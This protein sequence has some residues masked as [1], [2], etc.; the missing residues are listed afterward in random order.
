MDGLTNRKDGL[1]H[2]KEGKMRTEQEPGQC[3]E[4]Q[5]KQRTDKP[6]R[7]FANYDWQWG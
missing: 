1:T 3:K 2:R 4:K 5:S 6:S 7:T